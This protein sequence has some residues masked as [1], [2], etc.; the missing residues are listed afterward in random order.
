MLKILYGLNFSLIQTKHIVH[1]HTPTHTYNSFCG[2]LLYTHSLRC[3]HIRNRRQWWFNRQKEQHTPICIHTH[4][5]VQRPSQAAS[6]CF[7]CSVAK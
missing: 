2:P 4:M 3:K 7:V 5:H 1:T 6:P